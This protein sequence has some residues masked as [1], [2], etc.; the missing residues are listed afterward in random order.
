MPFPKPM[1]N[2]EAMKMPKK[3]K[4][5]GKLPMPDSVAAK[6]KGIMAS[7]DKKKRKY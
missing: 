3:K 2:A 6:V 1:S 4:S 5:L 7:V